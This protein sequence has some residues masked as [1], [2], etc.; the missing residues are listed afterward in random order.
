MRDSKAAKGR[1]LYP[2]EPQ[3]ANPATICAPTSRSGRQALGRRRLLSIIA[4]PDRVIKMDNRSCHHSAVI[5]C[6]EKDGLGHLGRLQQSSKRECGCRSV[7]EPALPGF[8]CLQLAFV[9]G[10]H[11]AD[12]E[13]VHTD[14]LAHESVA[15]VE[16]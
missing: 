15:R 6:Q 1:S 10:I 8:T 11:P 5:G 9:I 16:G 4:A 3:D 13:L 12:V 14:P 2:S 7:D